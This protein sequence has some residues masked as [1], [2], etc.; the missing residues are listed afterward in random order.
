[1][2]ALLMVV[3][4]AAIVAAAVGALVIAVGMF[5]SDMINILSAFAIP[6]IA[7]LAQGVT[8]VEL[9]RRSYIRHGWREGY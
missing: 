9:V 2:T 7:L 8:A 6:I 4:S 3:V 1:V 5:G